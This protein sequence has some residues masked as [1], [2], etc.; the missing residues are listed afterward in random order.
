[1]GKTTF[2]GGP[3]RKTTSH[4]FFA[5]SSRRGPRLEDEDHHGDGLEAQSHRRVEDEHHKVLVVPVAFDGERKKARA[6]RT[7]G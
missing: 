5:A 3:P 7:A 1:M 4:P 6:K 2:F